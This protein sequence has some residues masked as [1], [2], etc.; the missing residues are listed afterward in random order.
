[1]WSGPLPPPQI[2]EEFNNV[3]PNGAERIMAAW[4]RETDHRHKME[5][6]ELTLV[7]TDAI[8]GKI[9]AFL[10]VLGALSACAF[11]ASVGADWVAAIIGGGVI[12]S[13]VW[14][15]VRVNRPSKN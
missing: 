8:L 11:A 5:R 2:L 13:V 1:M 14:A 3:V 4:E 15:F 7:S 6:R 12:G 9:C 10:F